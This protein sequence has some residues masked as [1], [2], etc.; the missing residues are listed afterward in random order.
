MTNS[1]DHKNDNIPHEE[2]V[3]LTLEVRRLRELLEQLRLQQYIQVLLNKRRIMFI[4]FLSGL[5]SGLG[6]VL[7]GTLLLALLLYI[8][9]RLSI[10]PY[11]GHFISEIIKVVKKT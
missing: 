5:F 10:V 2:I 7:G 11:I 3:G 8:L 9:G 4:S 6:A 1:E